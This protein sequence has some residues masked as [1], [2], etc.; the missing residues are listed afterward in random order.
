ME[1]N[2]TP[3]TRSS[4][5]LHG[6]THTRQGWAYAVWD[7]EWRGGSYWSRHLLAQVNEFASCRAAETAM[8][9]RTTKEEEHRSVRAE[10]FEKYLLV[11]V[12]EQAAGIVRGSSRIALQLD[13]ERRLGDQ[14]HDDSKRWMPPSRARE[15]SGLA[16]VEEAPEGPGAVSASDGLA[17]ANQDKLIKPWWTAY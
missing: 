7:T 11:E 9:P 6:T 4:A 8:N 16:K 14:V 5:P 10:G 2:D 17:I 1:R 12:E 13:E 3:P 15:E